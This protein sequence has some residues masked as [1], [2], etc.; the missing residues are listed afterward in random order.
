MITG[1]ASSWRC[2]RSMEQAA[3]Y[4]AVNF[5]AEL[6]LPENMTISGPRPQRAVVPER[7]GRAA[8]RHADHVASYPGLQVALHQLRRLHGDE[9][10]LGVEPVVDTPLAALAAQ[11]N[12]SSSSTAGRGSLT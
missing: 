7:L 10:P 4:N 1:T 9:V 5:S 3:L 12:G 8:D 11:D 2:C 6:E